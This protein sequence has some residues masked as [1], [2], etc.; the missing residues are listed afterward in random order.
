VIFLVE[1]S[2]HAAFALD[3]VFKRNTSQLASQI[4]DPA[5]IDTVEF[6]DV[7][8]TLQ[9]QQV[10]AVD[11]AVDEGVDAALVFRHDMGGARERVFGLNVAQFH[12]RVFD[13]S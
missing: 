7:T 8:L 12:E 1:I 13:S 10:T 6:L 2:W 11:T 9:A 5:V 3:A 4:V